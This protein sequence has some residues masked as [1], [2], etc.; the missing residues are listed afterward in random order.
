MLW[1][2]KK[3]TQTDIEDTNLLYIQSVWSL[4]DL[5]KRANGLKSAKGGAV[6]GGGGGGANVDI[7]VCDG[8][9]K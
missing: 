4:R 1:K 2:L 7:R 6:A 8:L 5:H 3:K 9:I